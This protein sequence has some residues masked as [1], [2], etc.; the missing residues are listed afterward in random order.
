MS[1]SFAK[2]ALKKTF[3]RRSRSGVPHFGT[4]TVWIT[5]RSRSIEVG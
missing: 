4:V 5:S 1:G 2:R 3:I